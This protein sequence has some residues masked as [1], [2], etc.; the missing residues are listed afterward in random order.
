MDEAPSLMTE[1]RCVHRPGTAIR[2]MILDPM[3]PLSQPCSLRVPLATLTRAFHNSLALALNVPA[4]LGTGATAQHW[5]DFGVWT[6]PSPCAL[7][8]PCN[9]EGGSPA[10]SDPEEASPPIPSWSQPSPKA[11]TPPDTAPCHRP[12]LPCLIVQGFLNKTRNIL[13]AEAREPFPDILGYFEMLRGPP[14]CLTVVIVQ[15]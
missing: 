6:P 13:A 3:S 12:T 11:S 1:P 15:M 5:Q 14:S 4:C 2:A 8:S 10:R 7:T 9:P